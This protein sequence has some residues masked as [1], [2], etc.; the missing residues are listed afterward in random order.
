MGKAS[1]RNRSRTPSA[2]RTL[3][4]ETHPFFDSEFV[5]IAMSNDLLAMDVVKAMK[6]MVDEGYLTSWELGRKGTHISSR[7]CTADGSDDILTS[8]CP[9][10]EDFESLCKAHIQRALMLITGGGL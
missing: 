7:F 8:P 1:R 4:A 9:T 6:E 3:P 2:P 5:P 10:D